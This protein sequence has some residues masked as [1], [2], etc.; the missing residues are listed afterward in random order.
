MERGATSLLPYNTVRNYEN[1]IRL[2]QS[3]DESKGRGTYFLEM[4][5]NS[6]ETSIASSIFLIFAPSLTIAS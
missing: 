2:F 4:R 3:F 6:V 5:F 1:L